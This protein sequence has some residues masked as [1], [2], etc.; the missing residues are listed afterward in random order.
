MKLKMISV[1]NVIVVLSFITRPVVLVIFLM[2]F[3]F[4]IQI[5]FIFQKEIRQKI[6]QKAEGY[7]GSTR[8][9]YAC[10]SG[11][12]RNTNKCNYFVYDVGREAGAKM[13]VRSFG[14]GPVGA[15][16]GGWGTALSLSYWSRVLTPQRG[17]IVSAHDG[18]TYHMGIYVAYHTTV[19]ANSRNV[20]KNSWP[21]GYSGIVYWRYTG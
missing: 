14:R 18:G 21:R 2:R 4:Y 10:S 6:A 1:F 5:L 15:G 9:C 11:H 19:S 8:W 3:T 7:V 16:V 20:G 12:G 13:P 17:D